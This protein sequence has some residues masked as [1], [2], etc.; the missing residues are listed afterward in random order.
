VE[1]IHEQSWRIFRNDAVPLAERVEEKLSRYNFDTIKFAVQDNST[2]SALAPNGDIIPARRD[3]QG[4]LMGS[5]LSAL[6]LYC[7]QIS[8][9]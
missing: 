2:Y 3:N 4:A 5:Y 1:L 8:M 6:N 9:L 7:L